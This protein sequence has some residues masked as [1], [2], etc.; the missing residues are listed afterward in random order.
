LLGSLTAASKLT[1]EMLAETV[2]TSKRLRRTRRRCSE[3]VSQRL[4]RHFDDSI[5]AASATRQVGK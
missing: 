4:G 3:L 1:P 2:R 5:G